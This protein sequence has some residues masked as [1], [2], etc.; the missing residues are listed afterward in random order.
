MSSGNTNNNNESLSAGGSPILTHAQ[1]A[2]W[3]APAGEE[4]IEQISAHIERHLGPVK[5]VFHEI[6][7]DMVHI[8]VHFV[9][10]T[11]SVPYVRLV[12]S[13][14]SDLPMHMPANVDAPRHAE[15]MIT[16]PPD[17][18]LDEASFKNETWYWP[19]RLLKSLA[20][21]PHKHQTWIG[22]GHTIPHGDPAQPYAPNTKFNGA[23]ILPPLS[24]PE[25]FLELRIDAAKTI[26]FFAVVP[27]YEE[28]M[29]LK[30]SAGTDELLKRFDK[31]DLDDIVKP[32]R[33][34][35]ARKKLFGLF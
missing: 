25:D 15:L 16:L 29:Q 4:N 19:V 10:P 3:Q 23:L 14:M 32:G 5:T 22:W 31:H 2:E 26:A 13:G 9:P 34:N 7:S 35:L 17:W 21:L 33:A 8:D 28:E 27:L 12:T 6:I 20:R 30:L 18:K 11:A 24:A 1:A